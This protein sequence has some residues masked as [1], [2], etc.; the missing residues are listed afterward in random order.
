MRADSSTIRGCAL[1]P[2][3]GGVLATWC[4]DA[5]RVWDVDAVR[6]VS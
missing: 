4:S 2:A 1:S 3:D 5:V 6:S